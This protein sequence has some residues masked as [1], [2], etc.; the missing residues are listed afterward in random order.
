VLLR[1]PHVRLARC[2]PGRPRSQDRDVA[3]LER[4]P[5][6]AAEREQR[7]CGGQERPHQGLHPIQHDL[8]L[9]RGQRK[10]ARRRTLRDRVETR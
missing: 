3:T 7:E 6:D 1:D 5:C 2:A 9:R 8:P 10:L 4:E